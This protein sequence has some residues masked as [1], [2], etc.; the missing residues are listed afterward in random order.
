MFVEQ[1]AKHKRKA[2]E[3]SP[4]ER[5]KAV[6]LKGALLPIRQK[7]VAVPAQKVEE[8]GNGSAYV[9][10]RRARADARLVGIRKKKAEAAE[11]KAK[12]AK[13]D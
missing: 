1:T 9:T 10:L 7:V 8:T 11:E 6:Q 5:S 12:L 13:K 3:A 2:G 4:E